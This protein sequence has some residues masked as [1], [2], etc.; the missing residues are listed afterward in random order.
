MDMKELLA[1]KKRELKTKDAANIRPNKFADGQTTIV[2]LPGW[3]GAG[4]LQFWHDFGMHFV[5]HGK[6]K[7]YAHI[8]MD[9]TFEKECDI[10]AAIGQSISMSDDDDTIE[11]LKQV[12]ASQRYL[13]NAAQIKAGEVGDVEVYELPATVFEA[14]VDVMEEWDDIIGEKARPLIVNREGSGLSTKY[15]VTPSPKTIRI[16]DEKLKAV[17]DLDAVV[18]QTNPTKMKQVI[19]TI[20]AIAGIYDGEALAVPSKSKPKALAGGDFAKSKEIEE[21]DV[22]FETVEPE[23]PELDELDDLLDDVDLG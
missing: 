12:N 17:I 14:I 21:D 22:P 19:S 7:F 8:C 15:S 5:K 20:G 18:S 2:I 6:G 3:R 4:D 9:K 23:D 1:Q 13:V 11:A 10:C 16:P